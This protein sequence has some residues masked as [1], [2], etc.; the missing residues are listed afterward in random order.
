MDAFDF[1]SF[2]PGV[3]FLL[4]PASYDLL[5]VQAIEFNDQIRRSAYTFELVNNKL[6]IFP[7]PKQNYNLRFE[8]YKVNEKKAAGFL[9]GTGLVT[10]VAEVPYDNPSYNQIN[11]VGRQ[12]VFRYTLALAKELLAYV[13]GKYQTVPVPGSEA[14]LNQADLLTDA[15]S[16]KESLLTQL[17]EML[18]QTSRQAQLERKANEGENLKKTLGDVPMTIYVG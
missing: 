17:K 16:E 14:T 6:K 15:R 18:D 13:R 11:S 12:W 8:Y 5:K 10:N 4:M 7:L 2:S 1:G 3:N 9:D